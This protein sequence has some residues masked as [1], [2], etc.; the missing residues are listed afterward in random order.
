MNF[1]IMLKMDKDGNFTE[2]NSNGKV[3]TIDNWNKQFEKTDPAK[4]DK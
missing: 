3:Y 4:K 1:S 2:V